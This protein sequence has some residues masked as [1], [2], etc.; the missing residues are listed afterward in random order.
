MPK[1][2]KLVSTPGLK[3]YATF[4]KLTISN[5]HDYEKYL[6]SQYQHHQLQQQE[7]NSQLRK[8]NIYRRNPRLIQQYAPSVQN[9]HESTHF[10]YSK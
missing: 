3:H 10:I 7:E 1:K 8:Q 5:R 6:Q 9:Y 2:I 4:P